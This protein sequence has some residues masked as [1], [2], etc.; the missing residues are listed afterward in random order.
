MIIGSGI[1]L[2]EVARFRKELSR[3]PWSS[4]DGIFTENELQAFSHSNSVRTLATIFALK[5]ATLKA[6]GTGARSL[7]DFQEIE[8]GERIYPPRLKLTGKTLL[9]LR[10]VGASRVWCASASNRTVA[11]AVALLEP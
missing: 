11:I 5:E 2:V 8:V 6:L 10:A 1:D 9:R 4:N 7:S 3:A